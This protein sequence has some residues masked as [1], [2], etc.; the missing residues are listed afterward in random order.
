MKGPSPD[1]MHPIPNFPEILFLKNVIKTKNII[2]GDYTYCNDPLGP[3]GYVDRHIL[4]HYSFIGDRL[5][6][7]KFCSLARDIRFIMNGGNHNM[8]GFSTYPFQMFKEG[9]EEFDMYLNGI[10]LDI[11]V[12]LPL[13]GDINVG[14]DVWIGYGATILSGVTIGDGAV[15]GAKSV[16]TRDIPPYA[17]AAGNPARV[18]RKR[19]DEKTIEILEDVLWWD[20]PIESINK[21]MRFILD[22]DINALILINKK[23]H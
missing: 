4:H 5:I 6:I 18:I 9:W 8:K 16:V 11:P 17:I 13:R 22:G 12:D 2:V 20:W 15:I 14:N 3:E 19:F 7:G 1:V 23:L 10:S 21:A